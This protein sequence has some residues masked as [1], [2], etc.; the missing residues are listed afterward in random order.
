MDKSLTIL[1]ENLHGA[2]I[3]DSTS[4]AGRMIIGTKEGLSDVVI[5]GFKLIGQNGNGIL[6]GDFFND[7]YVTNCFIKNCFR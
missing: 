5:N 1:S 7:L 3:G 2:Q 4:L 6:V